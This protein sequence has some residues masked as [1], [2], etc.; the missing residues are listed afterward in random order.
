MDIINWCAENYDEMIV[1]ALAICGLAAHITALTPTP[2]DDAVVSK[3]LKV[4]DLFGG[5]YGRAKNGKAAE[6]KDAKTPDKPAE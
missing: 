6:P 3:I 1:I 4:L 2:K 5:N